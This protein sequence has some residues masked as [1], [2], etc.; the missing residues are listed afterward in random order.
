M[1]SAYFIEN[2]TPHIT[3]TKNNLKN[4]ILFLVKAM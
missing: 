3:T 1:N 2:K 4:S